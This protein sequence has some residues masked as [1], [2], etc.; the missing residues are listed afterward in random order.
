MAKRIIWTHASE[1]QLQV[2]LDFFIER[3]KSKIYSL[4]L[5]RKIHFEVN[6]LIKFPEMGK[7]TDF[8]GIRALIIVDYIVF[9][10]ELIDDIIIHKVWDSRQDERKLKF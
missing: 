1:I 8:V 2:I 5:Y 7:P 9:Y 3:N 4:K 6:K 10:E